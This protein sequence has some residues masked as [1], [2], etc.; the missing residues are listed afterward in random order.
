[1]ISERTAIQRLLKTLITWGPSDTKSLE[2]I[3]ADVTRPRKKPP[4]IVKNFTCTK[5]GKLYWAYKKRKEG[6]CA[7]CR[8]YA[9]RIAW[10][11]IHRI[12]T[13]VRTCVGCGKEFKATTD[14]KV[15]C[16]QYCLGRPT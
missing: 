4:P 11:K 7:R 10:G 3:L 1:M 2:Q 6:Q 8:Q 14:S 13:E 15:R 5:C 12:P 16:S 9:L